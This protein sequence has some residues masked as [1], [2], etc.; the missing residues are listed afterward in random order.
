MC[1]ANHWPV[2]R[3]D[4]TVSGV[5][6]TKLVDTFNDPASNSFAFLLSSKVSQSPSPSLPRSIRAADASSPHSLPRRAV[7]LLLVVLPPPPTR[8]AGAAST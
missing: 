2:L 3:L 5:K 8:P 4:G 1:A 6:R 7:L